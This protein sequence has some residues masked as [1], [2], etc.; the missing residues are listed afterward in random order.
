M[1]FTTD[2]RKVTIGLF[3]IFIVACSKDLDI[4]PPGPPNNDEKVQQTEIIAKLAGYDTIENG[5]YLPSRAAETD[6]IKVRTYLKSLIDLLSLPPLEHNYVTGNGQAGTN[7]YAI[8]PATVNSNEYIIVGAHYDSVN[9]SPGANDNATGV[10]MIFGLIKK[11]KKVP[12]RNKSVIFVF[13]DDEEIGLVG[14]GEFAEK[15]LLDS[16]NVH[17]V[18]TADQMGWDNDG[19]RAIELEAPTDYLK[20]KYQAAALENNIPVHITQSVSDHASFRSRGFNAIG[21]TEEY[22]NGDTT[23]YYHGAG[24]TYP[25]INFDYLTSSTLLMSK[26]ISNILSE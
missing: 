11:L 12:M 20:D 17:S 16:L 2:L 26:V 15:I 7:I 14:S 25:T 9:G 5:Y 23:P 22:V 10:A 21:L 19:D 6:K 18:H 24:D 3:I 4:A 8:L 1:T 13:F